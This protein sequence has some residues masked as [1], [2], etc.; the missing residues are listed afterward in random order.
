MLTADF[1]AQEAQAWAVVIAAVGLI[2]KLILD[3]FRERDKIKF[4]RDQAKLLDE[5]EYAKVLRDEAAAREVA[6]VKHN[7]EL[8]AAAQDKYAE[9]RHQQ[10]QGLTADIKEVHRLTNGMKDELVAEVKKTATAAGKKEEH[11]NP[12]ATGVG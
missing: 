2:V 12:T 7:L 3:F 8:T 5:R 11:D 6:T 9:E 4:D 1:G 10:I